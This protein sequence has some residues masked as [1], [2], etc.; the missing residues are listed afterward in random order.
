M[1]TPEGRLQKLMLGGAGLSCPRF[2]AALSRFEELH[3][4]E[5]EIAE[6]GGDTLANAAK[7]RVPAVCVFVF[8]S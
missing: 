6:F 3:T 8:L 4:L 2:P 7:V 1:C 5:L